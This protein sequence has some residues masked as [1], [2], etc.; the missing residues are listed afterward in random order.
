MGPGLHNPWTQA[1]FTG[2]VERTWYVTT[3]SVFILFNMNIVQEYTKNKFKKNYNKINRI[4]VEHKQ[5]TVS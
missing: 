2:R 5:Y 4:T 1:V 3:L